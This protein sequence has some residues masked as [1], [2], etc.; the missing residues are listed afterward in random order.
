MFVHETNVGSPLPTRRYLSHRGF[1]L[2]ELLVVIAIIAVL[3]ALL[4]PAVQKVREAANRAQ[5]VNNLRQIGIA[6]HTY[7]EKNGAF[8]DTFADVLAL[9]PLFPPDGAIHGF[10]L[11]PKI[12]ELQEVLI[13]AEPIPGV[14]GGDKLILHVL[15]PP[16][17]ALLASAPMPGAEEGRNQMFRNL[18]ALAAE[19]IAGLRYLLTSVE[20]AAAD[21]SVRPFLVEAPDSREVMSGLQQFSREGM[22]SLSSLFAAGQGPRSENGALQRRLFSLVDRSKAVLQIGAYN[23]GEHTGGVNLEDILRPGS[24]GAVPIYNFGDLKALT[25]AY[26]PSDNGFVAELLRW[27]DHAAHAAARGQDDLKQKFLDRY[28]GLLQKGSGRLLPAVQAEALIGIARTL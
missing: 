15:P 4:L 12:I 19:D 8:P 11:N 5:C 13:H 7:H 17:E 25:R 14:T 23:E 1:T 21:G 26:C 22:F 16:S 28:I 20:H 27:L 2:I 10:Q 6:L 3:I 9:E 18:M 24:Q